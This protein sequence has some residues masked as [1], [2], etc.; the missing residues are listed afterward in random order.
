VRALSDPSYTKSRTDVD[1]CHQKGLERLSVE[2][3]SAV[4][5]ADI[6]L[7]PDDGF[8]D[9]DGPVFPQGTVEFFQFLRNHAP[10]GAAVAIAVE[11]A[12]YKEVV[13]HSDMVRLGTI[14]VEYVGAPIVM[15]L[16]AAY[17][18]DFLGS[19]LKSTEARTAIIVHRKDGAIEQTVRI[20]YEGPAQNV[21]AALNA[22]I[23]SLPLKADEPPPVTT[24]DTLR[25]KRPAPKQTRR[26]KQ[27]RK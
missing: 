14:F 19:R 7:V 12:D 13:L 3:R 24:T 16:I 2:L 4:D 25:A 9:Y 1:L 22:A 21:E 20:S 26:K 10:V 18:K 17:L 6:V 23:A 11:D 5:R 15:S 27:R 8:G